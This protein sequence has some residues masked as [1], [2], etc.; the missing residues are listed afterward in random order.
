LAKDEI[1]IENLNLLNED[2][3][4]DDADMNIETDKQYRKMYF[5]KIASVHNSY[6]GHLG[7][8]NTNDK[9]DRLG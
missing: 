5:S 7:V 6:V 4:E 8:E 9:L 1:T 3:D 2:N